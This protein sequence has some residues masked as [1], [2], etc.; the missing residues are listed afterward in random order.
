MAG[1]R[2]GVVTRWRAEEGFYLADPI[3][4]KRV[5]VCSPPRCNERSHILR[6]FYV[7]FK[8]GASELNL[9]KRIS[10]EVQYFWRKEREALKTVP[11]PKD[12]IYF[13]TDDRENVKKLCLEFFQFSTKTTQYKQ[14]EDESFDK[15]S[16]FVCYLGY[17]FWE[18][19]V[20]TISL[21]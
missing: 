11:E 8:Y 13:I 10:S 5:R 17:S 20:K 15:E 6:P 16:V 21:N 2:S 4:R 12:G 7:T 19:K 1:S 3:P 9:Y 18:D 14:Y